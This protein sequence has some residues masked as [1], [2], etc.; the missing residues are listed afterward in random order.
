MINSILVLFCIA[1]AVN[2]CE[3]IDEREEF[4]RVQY[5]SEDNPYFS[6]HDIGSNFSLSL[7]RKGTNQLGGGLSGN[8][9]PEADSINLFDSYLQALNKIVK[10][11]IYHPK[12]YET[13]DQSIVI[14]GNLQHPV[15]S[16]MGNIPDFPSQRIIFRVPLYETIVCNLNS[17]SQ[18][19]IYFS[20]LSLDAVS[21]DGKYFNNVRSIQWQKNDMCKKPI[22][23]SKSLTEFSFCV[24]SSTTIDE[25]DKKAITLFNIG[26]LLAQ[27]EIKELDSLKESFPATLE[28]LEKFKKHLPVV[29]KEIITKL[30]SK[31]SITKK[32]KPAEGDVIKMQDQCLGRK[33]TELIGRLLGLSYEAMEKLEA[34]EENVTQ[35]PEVMNNKDEVMGTISPEVI[36]S[37][38]EEVTKDASEKSLLTE[39]LELETV[40][41]YLQG[42]SQISEYLITADYFDTNFKIAFDVKKNEIAASKKVI[43]LKRLLAI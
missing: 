29:Q 11:D 33:L 25:K 15:L 22:N 13:E 36:D 19:Q 37:E 41:A 26:M 30:K 18:S 5:L 4:K 27:I 38:E 35:G 1:S 9:A 21:L 24:D 12:C 28:G 20:D 14:L 23:A 32:D 17:L 10:I 39:E 43:K 6:F 16:K 3:P 7:W 34:E 8:V 31:F 2:T 40:C 42:L